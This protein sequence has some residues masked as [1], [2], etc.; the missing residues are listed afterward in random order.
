M[1]F[2]LVRLLEIYGFDHIL[3]PFIL[4]SS[5]GMVRV[6]L[7]Q[8]LCLSTFKNLGFQKPNTLN[9]PISEGRINLNHTHNLAIFQNHPWLIFL[10]SGI[11]FMTTCLFIIF[12]KKISACMWL[13]LATCMLMNNVKCWY[14][15]WKMLIL[16]QIT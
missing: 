2:E 7:H 15:C 11:K 1:L 8:D 3:T 12:C 16:S 4:L 5:S 6:S 10:P 14:F 13:V 9:K